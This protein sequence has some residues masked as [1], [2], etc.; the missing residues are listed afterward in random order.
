MLKPGSPP[1]GAVS[2]GSPTLHTH[3]VNGM[4]PSALYPTQSLAGASVCFRVSAHTHARSLAGLPARPRDSWVCPVP[5]NQSHVYF[6]P[7]LTGRWRF[8]PPLFASPSCSQM[9]HDG[10]PPCCVPAHPGVHC[11][12]PLLRPSTPRVTCARPDGETVV[13]CGIE[14]A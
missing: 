14:A 3:K 10:A 13:P 9:G 11:L 2:P 12:P 5:S 7:F 8:R 6:L 1:R 4:P